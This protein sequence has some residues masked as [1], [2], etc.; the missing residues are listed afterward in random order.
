MSDILTMNKDIV[1]ASGRPINIP[2]VDEVKPEEIPIEE[3][4]LQLPEPKGY[5]ILCAIPDASEEYESGILKAGS[6]KSIE[7]LSTVVLFVVK[8]GDLAYKDES[9]F[10]T[11]PWCKEG[12]FVLTRAYAGTRFK[13]HGREFRII[14]D[15]TVEGVVQDPRGYTRA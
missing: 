1:D 12:D 2:T 6:T 7:E 5:K 15:D 13:I 3:R 9:R 10:P 11:G 8:V 4:G 14:N